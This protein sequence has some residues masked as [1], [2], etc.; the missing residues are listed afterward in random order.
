MLIVDKVFFTF[1]LLIKTLF[2]LAILVKYNFLSSFYVVG[3]KYGGV[4]YLTG[5]HAFQATKCV[6]E[7]DRNKIRNTEMP[8]GAKRIGRRV[9]LR[10]KFESTRM[11]KMLK[12]TDG[13]QIIE[14]NN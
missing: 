11:E 14:K 3:I 10:N 13:K 6:E 9:E 4:A 8:G 12:D 1:F 2:V 7:S 5:E